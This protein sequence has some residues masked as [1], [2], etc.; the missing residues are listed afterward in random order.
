MLGLAEGADGLLLLL[1]GARAGASEAAERV[2]ETSWCAWYSRRRRGSLSPKWMRLEEVEEDT[3]A[4]AETV[5]GSNGV[6][7]GIA[8]RGR[9]VA[10]KQQVAELVE[11]LRVGTLARMGP[12]C[13]SRWGPR[14]LRLLPP[15][16]RILTALLRQ[17]RWHRPRAK[18]D[19]GDDKRH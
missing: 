9:M 18:N 1:E 13:Y 12:L 17:L 15:K 11:G 3:A 8:V 6:V 16:Q 10:E 7:K 19:L 14:P 5:R 4:G 2:G